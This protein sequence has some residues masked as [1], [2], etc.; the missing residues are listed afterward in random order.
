MTGKLLAWINE[1]REYEYID[2][3]SEYDAGYNAAVDSI[4]DLV[5][6]MQRSFL[7]IFAGD[8]E[9]PESWDFET[10]L[11]TGDKR[12]MLEQIEMLRKLLVEWLE[13]ESSGG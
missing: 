5:A 6:E 8:F 2:P 11:R 9:R 7:D 1:K 13:A 10:V 4:E 12:L 3:E